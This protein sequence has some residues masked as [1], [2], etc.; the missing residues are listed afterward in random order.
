MFL[1][2]NISMSK[3]RI[4]LGLGILTSVMPYLG[5]PYAIKNILLTLFGLGIV[6]LSLAL[7]YAENKK[8]LK[9]K[10]NFENFSENHDFVE[11]LESTQ[12][13]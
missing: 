4:F 13:I 8:N 2:Y 1:E 9:K 12:Q 11:S 5:F 7:L 10:G 6:C 3:V